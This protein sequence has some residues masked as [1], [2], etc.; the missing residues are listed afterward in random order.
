MRHKRLIKRQKGIVDKGYERKISEN[1]LDCNFLEEAKYY[2][3]DLAILRPAGHF[4]PDNV[5]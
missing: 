5:L 2:R 1:F 4:H 3:A